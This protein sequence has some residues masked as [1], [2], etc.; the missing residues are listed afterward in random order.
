MLVA[1]AVM[2]MVASSMSYAASGTV[3]IRAGK[4]GFIVGVGGGSGVLHFRGRNYPLSV[5]GLSAGTIGVSSVDLVGTASN[6]RTAA[7]IAGSYSA[8][9]SGVA[10]AGGVQAARLQNANGVVL[11]LRGRQAGFSASFGFGGITIALR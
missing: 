5:S 9:G 7:D 8:I 2:M 6:L 11:E 4:A 3:R 10:V 1:A